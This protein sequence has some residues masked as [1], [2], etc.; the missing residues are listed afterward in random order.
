MITKQLFFLMMGSW[1]LINEGVDALFTILASPKSLSGENRLLLFL[2]ATLEI[3]PG[4]YF[5]YAAVTLGT[6]E[7]T[8]FIT[9]FSIICI[10]GL[11]MLALKNVYMSHKANVSV[12][13]KKNSGVPFIEAVIITATLIIAAIGRR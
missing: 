6:P 4:A 1:L 9:A 10:C 11:L 12:V 7:E 8:A 5:E 3:V 13:C 2:K